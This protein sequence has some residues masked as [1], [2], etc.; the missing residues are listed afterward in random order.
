MALEFNLDFSPPRDEPVTVAPRV[1]RVTAGNSGPFTFRGTNTFLIGEDALAV[2]DPGP[3]D[4][5]HIDAVLRAIGGARVAHILVS[6]T[7]RDHSPGARLLKSRTGAPILAAGPHRLARPPRA[8]EDAR[9]EAGADLD[10]VPDDTLT[11]GAV[12]ESDSY[13]LEAVATPGH[14]ANHLAFA[15]PDAGIIFSGDHVMGWSTTVVA[16]PDGSMADYMASLEKLAARPERL[17]LP[18]HGAEIRN[19]PD[20]ARAL[21]THRKMREAAILDGLRRGDASIPELVARVY[22]GLNPLLSGAA[23]LSTL[24]HLE[25]LVARGAVSADG[26]PTLEACYWLAEATPLPSAPGRG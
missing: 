24:A 10:F 23:A 14:T 16:P 7:H 6:H 13:R 18:A 3:A 1:R 9:L 21:R 20:F 15:W 25:D 8:G 11:D 12:V 19:G 17:Y 4:P 5:S 26:P 22:A 2:L